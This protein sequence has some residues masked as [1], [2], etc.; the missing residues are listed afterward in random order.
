[1]L[2]PHDSKNKAVSVTGEKGLRAVVNELGVVRD[3]VRQQHQ[4][5]AMT[6]IPNLRPLTP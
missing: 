5:S 6:F 2:P 4:H 1:M 3:P